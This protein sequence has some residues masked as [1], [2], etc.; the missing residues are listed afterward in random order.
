[1]QQNWPRVPDSWK[2]LGFFWGGPPTLQSSL[3][4]S[5]PGQIP[6]HLSRWGGEDLWVTATGCL[7]TGCWVRWLRSKAG[8]LFSR[9]YKVN[10]DK[11]LTPWGTRTVES[12]QCQNLGQNGALPA[13]PR[14]SLIRGPS[15]SPSLGSRCQ[16][17][18]W[19]GF[20]MLP[21]PK[22]GLVLA[23]PTFRI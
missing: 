22:S 6:S 14:V 5:A 23:F 19:S 11:A 21:S 15:G 10:R 1:M 8:K 7:C 17:P 16:I 4:G 9:R 12:V 18:K 13:C 2:V 20:F 3:T